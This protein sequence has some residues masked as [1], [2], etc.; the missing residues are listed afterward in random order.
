MSCAGIQ[1]ATI[2]DIQTG[3]GVPKT[4]TVHTPNYEMHPPNHVCQ[5]RRRHVV[6]GDFDYARDNWSI[7]ECI[8]PPLHPVPPAAVL[9]SLYTPP[10][11]YECYPRCPK[12]PCNYDNNHVVEINLAPIHSVLDKLKNG[13]SYFGYLGCKTVLQITGRNGGEASEM[14]E[15][16]PSCNEDKKTK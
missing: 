1:Y 13:L 6:A 5:L 4:L 7:P 3:R 12:P 8:L 16:N 15:D 9:H 11:T 14:K 10:Q 2:N